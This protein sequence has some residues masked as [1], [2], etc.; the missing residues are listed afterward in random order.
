MT[1]PVRYESEVNTALTRAAGRYRSHDDDGTAYWLEEAIRLAPWRRD[2]RFCLAGRHVQHGVPALAAAE[3]ERVL[4]LIPADADAL[5]FAA[6]WRRCLGDGE[7]ARGHLEELRT[8]RPERAEALERVWAA[9][10][11]WKGREV[12]DAVPELP[13]SAKR[14]AVLILGHVLNDDGT[15]KPALICRLKKAL[16]VLDRYPEA[17]AV[18]SGGVPRAGRVEAT[19]MR[20]WLV[21]QGVRDSRIHEEGYSRDVVENLIFSREILSVLGVDAVAAVTCASNVRRTGAGLEILSG[22]FG[23]GWSV[24]VAAAAGP[25]FENFVDN[26][27]DGLKLYRDTLRTFGVPMMTAYPFLAER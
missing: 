11:R 23:L 12:T 9:I 1:S 10:D 4:E 15:P 21:G 26:G 19:T 2:V 27:G 22:E 25:T 13:A 18:A 8:I 3:Y 17:V 6:H 7:L 24:G 20:E 5:F 16:E 14:P